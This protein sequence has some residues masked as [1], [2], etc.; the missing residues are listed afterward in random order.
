MTN[1]ENFTDEIV[2]RAIAVAAT[3]TASEVRMMRV[4]VMYTLLHST[5]PDE[6]KEAKRLFIDSLAQAEPAALLL[7]LHEIS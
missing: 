3:L 2:E 7:L 4:G 1:T 5:K 6:N